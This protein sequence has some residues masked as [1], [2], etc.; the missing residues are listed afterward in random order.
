MRVDNIFN[1]VHHFGSE[2]DQVSA[3]FTFILKINEKVFQEF[4]ESIGI[5][6]NRQELRRIDIKTQVNY[7][8]IGRID[9]H[10]MLK[11]KFIVFI[12]SKIWG[13]KPNGQQLNKYAKVLEGIRQEYGNDVRLVLITHLDREEMFSEIS[14]EI[15]LSAN[16]KYHYRWKDL[17]EIIERSY[18][19]GQRRFINRMF[20]NY[21]GDK[22]KDVKIIE[23]QQIKDVEEII[24]VS[25]TPEF[26]EINKSRLFCTQAMKKGASNAQYVAFYRTSP[27]SAVT[28]IAK[29]IK[30]ESNVPVAEIYENTSIADE[31]KSW[32]FDKVFRLQKI[33]ELP[34]E[35]KA[36]K[37]LKQIRT[38]KYA[39]FDR[40]LTAKT[41]DEL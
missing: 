2:E 25:T 22:M 23:D 10:I 38:F 31:T 1:L 3:C 15:P 27:V 7:N 40:L 20:L 8:G 12:E 26:W 5:H 17:Q 36:G 28:H 9:I 29:V 18:A 34:K 35:I 6:V 39:T 32:G 13:R 4:L 33:M 37:K 30:T 41:L 24:I 21:I 19:S 16:E 14:K 11:N